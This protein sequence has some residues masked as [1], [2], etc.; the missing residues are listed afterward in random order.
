MVPGNVCSTPDS[1]R[2]VSPLK[3]SAKCQFR[4]FGLSAESERG[5]RTD[6][7]EPFVY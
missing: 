1:G 7:F 4:K 2:A 6:R 3:E 5:H